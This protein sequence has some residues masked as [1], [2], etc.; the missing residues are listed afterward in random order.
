MPKRRLGERVRAEG[1]PITAS[2]RIREP[3][4]EYVA[5]NNTVRFPAATSGG[6]VSEYSYAPFEEWASWRAG[7]IARASVEE[8]LQSRLD[9]PELVR[10]G[11]GVDG[12][13]FEAVVVRHVTRHEHDGTATE[14]P[15]LGVGTLVA[16]LPRT[17]TATVLFAGRDSIHDCPVFV[18]RAAV[19]S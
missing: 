1:E 12:A 7:D 14:A 5:S 16:T 11:A 3:H 13:P 8:A 15:E 18:Q 2:D 4:Y 10:V 9:A 6:E 17:V 19:I